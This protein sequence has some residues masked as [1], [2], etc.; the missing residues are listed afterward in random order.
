[1]WEGRKKGK[2]GGD[3]ALYQFM[4]KYGNN[5]YSLNLRQTFFLSKKRKDEKGDLDVI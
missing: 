2:G 4:S 3:G 5:E 1:L